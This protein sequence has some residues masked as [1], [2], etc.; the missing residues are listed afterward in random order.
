MTPSGASS[1]KGNIS[2]ACLYCHAP[3][4]A[5]PNSGPLWN[6]QLST[7]VYSLYESPT[8]HQTGT[9]PMIGN[10]SKLC[11]SCHDGTVAPGQTVSFGKLATLGSMK[12]GS[13]F[14]ADLRGT[15]PFSLQTPLRD[16][17]NLNAL[18][19]GA[20]PRTADP[21][22]KL[23][24]G[25]V[26]CTSCHQ[27]HFQNVDKVVFKFLVRDSANGAL[28]LACH[29]PSRAVAGQSNY[30]TGWSVAVH[31]TSA[32]ATQ[33]TP[34][35][36]G[37]GT[38]AENACNSCHMPHNAL[39][40]VRLLRGG[41]EQACASCH[42][43]SNMQPE[44]SN[45]FAEFAKIG[46]PFPAGNNT[47]DRA[48]AAVLNNNRHATCADCHN[49]HADQAVSLFGAPPDIRLSQNRVVGVSSIDGTTVVSPAINQFE[50]CLRCHGTSVGKVVDPKY[51]YSPN[52]AVRASD[53]LNLVP[54]FSA[55]A[56][57]SHPVT[58]DRSSPYSQPSLRP[59]MLQLDGVTAGRAMGTRTFCTDCHNSDDA[60]ESGGTG[61]NGPHGSKWTH[62]FER[63]YEMSQAAAAGTAV[64]NTFPNPDLGVN[65]PYSLCSKCH[66]LDRVLSSTSPFPAHA[67]HVNDQG[68]SCSTC[69]TG[70]GNGGQNPAIS[71]ERLVNFDL[72]VV[73]QFNNQPVAFSKAQRSCTLTCHG[74]NH[75]NR[76][77]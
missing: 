34:D 65:G 38:V 75:D 54:Q 44:L 33:N 68:L 60:R 66:D 73:G 11:L 18:L 45:V 70:H 53:P 3:H 35:V 63:R 40:P 50:S 28:C 41:N 21:A 71:G 2:S 32:Q 49:P 4:G 14:G 13:Q 67:A 61:P 64:I 37:Y 47:H 10:P 46:H 48:E 74:S 15:H 77:Y 6:Q 72:N 62:I 55:S 59:Q 42:S 31:A 9:Q 29:D 12:P 7:Q 51:G 5:M 24:N 26:E 22:V 23:V 36:G 19:T 8:Y 56:T 58:H 20:P 1:V 69:H 52:W 43:G 76:K 39:G 25:S 30:L 16:A 27:P 57:S 17:P